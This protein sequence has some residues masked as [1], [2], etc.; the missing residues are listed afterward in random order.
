MLEFDMSIQ[1]S[2]DQAGFGPAFIAKLYAEAVER[3]KEN[4]E[5]LAKTMTE[6]SP[7]LER[8]TAAEAMPYAELQSIGSRF[9]R[10]IV[11]AEIELC[12][13]YEK[14]WSQYLELPDTIASCKSPADLAQ[15]Q[16]EFCSRLTAD[17]AAEGSKFLAF[18]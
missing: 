5:G 15:V 17:Y 18:L 3:W 16:T 14:R 13:F 8:K 9:F 7:A 2:L 4:Y 6:P 12:R 1:P 11:E 10:N